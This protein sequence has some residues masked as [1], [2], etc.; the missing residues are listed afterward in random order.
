MMGIQRL[1]REI[2]VHCL[3]QHSTEDG[4]IKWRQLE[5]GSKQT[6]RHSS[7]HNIL[8][9]YGTPVDAKSLLEFKKCVGMC[10]EEKSIKGT[11][12]KTTVSGT[13]SPGAVNCEALREYPG[14]L[15]CTCPTI[16]H[17]PRLLTSI[18][19][20]RYWASIFCLAQ[21]NHFYIPMF[22]GKTWQLRCLKEICSPML[23]LIKRSSDKRLWSYKYT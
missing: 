15:S 11:K 13:E 21:H 23:R 14:D 19:E 17:F 2:T 3:S 22:Q 6:R 10:R 8:A 18:R 16:T 1:N 20:T 7:S 4:G 12:S 5:P 9:S